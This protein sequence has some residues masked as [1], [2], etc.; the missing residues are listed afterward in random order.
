VFA[1]GLEAA[2]MLLQAYGLSETEAN[3][4]TVIFAAHDKSLLETTM[5]QNMD[6]NQLIAVSK[7]GRQELQN[8]FEE[9]KQNID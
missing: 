1:G 6:F 3:G 8:L 2:N 9:D 7:K 5:M 4:L